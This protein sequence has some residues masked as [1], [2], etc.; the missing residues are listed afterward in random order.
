M[1]D[2]KKAFGTYEEYQKFVEETADEIATN[3]E[4]DARLRQG[5]SSEDEDEAQTGRW[6]WY[7]S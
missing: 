3:L 1:E 5:D 2:S 7:I 6:N 4:R